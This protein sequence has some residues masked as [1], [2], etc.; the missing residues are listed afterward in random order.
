MCIMDMFIINNCRITDTSHF[1]HRR[2]PLLDHIIP[3]FVCFLSDNT[4]LIGFVSELG[5]TKSYRIHQSLS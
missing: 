1:P 3:C 5:T 4:G 2:L